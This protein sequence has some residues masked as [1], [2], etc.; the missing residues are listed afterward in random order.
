LA[1]LNATRT[2]LLRVTDAP[3]ELPADW[4]NREHSRTVTIDSMRWHVQRAGSG[5]TV[6][7][8]HGTAGATHTWAR[9]FSALRSTCDCIA[10]DLPGHGFTRG[11]IDAQMS[12]DAMT[13]AIERVLTGLDVS[14]KIGVGHSAGV[15]VLLCAQARERGA[16]FD[17]IVGVNAALVPPLQFMQ[18]V[19]QP[20]TRELFSFL[21][22]TALAA[23]VL[24]RGGLARQLM[25]TTGTVLTPAQESRYIALLSDERHVRAAVQMMARWDLPALQRV[26]A[27]ITCPV[28][29]L[30]SQ[31]EPWVPWRELDAATR[32]LP[33]RTL[34]D[35]PGAGHLIPEEKPE[36]VVNAVR[37]ALRA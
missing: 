36:L 15:A 1:E 32:T 5:P 2:L 12:L 22:V 10:I 19:L 17:A 8:L 37:E 29:L 4:P 3:A 24:G 21:P 31:V 33:H 6:L 9:V 13:V 27:T 20:V 18:N 35:V 25:R 34:I 28:T 11:A 30:H 23:A 16:G 26:M 7:M 14:P